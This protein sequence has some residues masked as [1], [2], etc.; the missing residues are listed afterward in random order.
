MSSYCDIAP[1]HPVHGHY[2]DHE[3]GVP[4]RAEADLFE[5][6]VLEINQ[7]GLSW[8]LMLKKRAGFRA[9]YAGFD[10]DTVAAFGETDVLRLLGDAGII[11]N[12]LK[13]QAAIHNA[14]VIQRLRASH[15]SFAAW[16]DAQH[17]RS[18]AEWIKLFKRTFRFTGGEIT[19]EFLMSLGY[20]PGAHREDCPAFARIVQLDPPWMRSA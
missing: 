11:R 8:E 17:P 7:A 15:G 9:A 2:H 19:G 10:V 14:Q 12:R 18:K 16:L 4:Q 3:Y 6:L 5:R 20:L 13:V 1:G